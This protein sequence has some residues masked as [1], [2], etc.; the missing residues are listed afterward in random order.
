V[1]IRWEKCASGKP[2]QFHR[3]ANNGHAWPGG[4][5]GRAEADQPTQ[6]LNASEMMWS[7]FTAN[8]K[9]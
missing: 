6:A 4:R 2:V 8:P 9:R 5:A 7:F 3:V 1:E